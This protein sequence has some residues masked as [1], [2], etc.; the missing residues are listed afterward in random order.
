[1][2]FGL[3][4]APSTF[5]RLMERLFGDQRHQSVLLYLD[6]I[7]VFSSSVQQHLQRLRVVLGRLKTEGLKV[8][9]EKC[10]FFQ[11]EV[12]YLG[13]VIS[14][15]GVATDPK[16]IEAV[17][18]WPHPTTVSE[19]RTFLG[20]VSYYRRFVEGFA[21]LAAPLHKVVAMLT[22]GKSSKRGQEITTVWS[23]QCEEA[24]QVLKCVL[25]TAPVLAYADF[26]RP[27]ILE[28]DASHGGLGAVLSQEFDGKIRPV[29]YAS[30]S[31]RPSERNNATYSS[32]RL[33]FLAL[34]WA[35]GKKIQRVLAWPQVPGTY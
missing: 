16:K 14:S 6:D 18:Q 23:E 22:G 27:F 7:I 25:T 20:F 28:V 33:E 32:M 17:A 13:H 8:K 9:L 5:Q 31:L 4:N 1:M 11:E 15:R 2:P 35:M 30:R 21:K 34:K 12:S 10:A 3:C 19:L 29:A 26:T 24:F